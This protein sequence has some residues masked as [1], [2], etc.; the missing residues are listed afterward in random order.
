MGKCGA[1]RESRPHPTKPLEDG[2]SKRYRPYRDVE[3]MG[4]ILTDRAGEHGSCCSA[5]G[6]AARLNT[7]DITVRGAG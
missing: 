5:I 2:V 7:G 4:R 1:G 3:T 6:F